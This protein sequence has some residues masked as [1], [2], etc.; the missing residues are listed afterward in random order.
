MMP[1]IPV[2]AS[3]HFTAGGRRA[4][5]L[6][7]SVKSGRMPGSGE[8]GKHHKTV[9]SLFRYYKKVLVEGGPA[10]RPQ[11][12]RRAGGS[13]RCSKPPSDAR[14]VRNVELPRRNVG[15]LIC[16]PPNPD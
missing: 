12:P 2:Q 14:F 5:S 9:S 1:A 11:A 8:N 7:F 13:T 16:L 3:R 4:H 10:L 15:D 6:A